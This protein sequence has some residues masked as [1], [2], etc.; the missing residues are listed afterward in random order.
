[1]KQKYKPV[2]GLE[3]H[4]Q[5][6]TKTKMFSPESYEYGNLPNTTV[7]AVTL[8]HP[9]AMPTVNKLAIEYAIKMGLACKCN[10]NKVNMFARK[11]YFYPDLPKGYQITQHEG[12]ICYDGHITIDSHSSSINVSEK[13]IRITR[14]HI[15]EDTGKVLHDII[16]GK[17]LI[18]YN[19]AGA[20]LIEIVTEP[21]ITTSEDAYTFLHEARK[22]V[23]YLE[24][25]DGN[26][27]E[28][29]LRCDANVSVM[30]IEDTKYGQ[31]VEVKNINSIRNVQAAIEYEISRQ[32]QLLEQKSTVKPETRSFNAKKG[33]TIGMRTKETLDDYR[34]F[35]EPDISPIIVDDKWI[36]S[37]KSK[38]PT[39]AR[40]YTKKFVNHY[41][42]PFKDAKTIS[43][44]KHLAQY[45]EKA[46]KDTQN[47]KSAANWIIGPIKSYLNDIKIGI[48]EF[49]IS[50]KQVSCLV[51]IIDEGKI[52]MSKAIQS[53]FPTMLEQPGLPITQ[54]LEQKNLVQEQNSTKIENYINEVIKRYPEKVELY[55]KGKTGLLGF[56]MGEIM[57]ISQGKADPK[58]A[59]AILK[60]LLGG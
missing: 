3:I 60:E 58:I 30:K 45:Y 49:K 42:I 9:G 44:D 19:R 23:R 31:R 34:Y 16:P 27:E 57:K 39:M 51:N 56:F 50:P 55:K 7:S 5:L 28:G 59:S 48:S 24:I 22:I 54:I 29:S 53:V 4:A 43:E 11:N 46:C 17:T 8:A 41:G 35:P 20:P 1:M 38:I 52:S 18:D 47:Y 32:I 40:E 21:D 26:M 37:I 15:E 33:I 6:S 2:I 13:K 12:P 10:I 36:Q 14:I 25:C